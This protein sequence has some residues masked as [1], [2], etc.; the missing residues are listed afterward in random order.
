[1]WKVMHHLFPVRFNLFKRRITDSLTSPICERE[2]ETITHALWT[3][4]TALD[5]WV[6]EESPRQ[7]WVCNEVEIGVMGQTS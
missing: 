2:S 3:C 7:K 4:P 5:V 6:E 1:M